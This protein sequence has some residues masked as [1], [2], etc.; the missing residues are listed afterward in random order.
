MFGVNLET[1][2]SRDNHIIYVVKSTA[3]KLELTNQV[4]TLLHRLNHLHFTKFKSKTTF[5]YIFINQIN[6]N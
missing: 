6:I 1:E 5:N 2:L 4:Q 3:S